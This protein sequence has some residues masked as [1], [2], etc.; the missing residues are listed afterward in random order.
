MSLTAVALNIF[1]Y[2]D[3]ILAPIDTCINALVVR[4]AMQMARFIGGERFITIQWLEKKQTAQDLVK[5]NLLR[6]II[7]PISI[8]GIIIW[9]SI[10]ISSILDLLEKFG[11][12]GEKLT[13]TIVPFEKGKELFQ[14]SSGAYLLR[15]L[16]MSVITILSGFNLLV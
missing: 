6:R 8:I 11:A 15:S 7:A 13:D 16:Y 1:Y 5:P 10:G 12:A 4:G 3:R 2:I 14:E 9:R